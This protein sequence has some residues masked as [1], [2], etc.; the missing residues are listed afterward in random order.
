MMKAVIH[1][2]FHNLSLSEEGIKRL[3]GDPTVT[4]GMMSAVKGIARWGILQ[5]QPAGVPVVV[6]WNFT[7][8]CNLNCLHCHQDSIF[9]S[10]NRHTLDRHELNRSE[11]F[12][13]VENMANAGVSILTFS[14]GEPLTRLDLY[15]VVKY[16]DDNGMHCTLATNGTLIDDKVAERLYDSGIRGVEIGLD[17][18][19]QETHDLLRNSPGS[20]NAAIKGIKSCVNLGSFEDVAIAATLYRGNIKE[21]PSIIDL[22]EELG[23]TKFY[24]NR[25]IAAGRGKN[26]SYLDVSNDE[27]MKALDHLYDRFHRA[28]H[29]EGIL[30][31]ARGMT[32]FA[33]VCYER[34]N[35]GI[36]P[37]SE[38]LTGYEGM[39]K[40]FSSEIPKI[41]QK[42]AKG[43]GGCSAGLTYCG[44]NAQGDLLPC[45]IAPI[46]LGNLLEED[47]EEIWV[48]SKVLNY[49]RGRFTE[50]ESD[51]ASQNRHI[52]RRKLK[53]SCG[54]CDYNEICGGCRY[55]A[56]EMLG[57][58][59]S[60]DLSCPYGAKT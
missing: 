29:G 8:R 22:A 49:I 44:L 42:L 3:V 57:D 18:A 5:P 37:V 46:N 38:V 23:A 59:L 6:V 36:F 20:F 48:E 40:D 19:T 14:G 32:Y 27:R 55:T 58:W 45:V 53:G 50:G 24:L 15:D 43:F 7:N 12:K 35:G 10:G 41:V 33:R 60:P 21:L 54:R 28:T 31:Y 39:F 1:R 16:A 56:Y 13:V 52:D 30:C 34:S 9:P 2:F 26:A 47:L 4:R 51:F 17:G 25:I 11:A